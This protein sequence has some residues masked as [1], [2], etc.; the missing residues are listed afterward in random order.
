MKPGFGL[1][2]SVIR[3]D[4]QPQVEKDLFRLGSKNA[5]P[6]TLLLQTR[7]APHESLP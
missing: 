5:M 7:S 2:V 3:N 6:L 4:Q 1:R